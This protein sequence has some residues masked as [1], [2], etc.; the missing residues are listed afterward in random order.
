MEFVR[1][2]GVIYGVSGGFPTSMA[3][4]R[5]TIAKPLTKALNIEVVT[6]ESRRDSSLNCLPMLE[7]YRAIY[8]SRSNLLPRIATMPV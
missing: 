7:D 6:Q 1:Q 4:Q 3:W 8:A 2:I 5:S